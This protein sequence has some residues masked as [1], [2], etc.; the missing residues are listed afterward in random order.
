MGITQ[1]D[2]VN[3]LNKLIEKKGG[4]VV[5]YTASYCAP[6][7]AMKGIVESL[8]KDVKF[9]VV[10]LDSVSVNVSS[11][12]LFVAYNGGVEVGRVEGASKAA[13]E[14]LVGR[15]KF[16]ALENSMKVKANF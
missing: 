5:Y 3:Q 14:K 8:S 2:S 11:I 15:L 13:L 7:R 6:C 1:I 10:S 4:V 16:T 12:P 9:L